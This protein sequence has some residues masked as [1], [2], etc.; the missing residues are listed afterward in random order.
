MGYFTPDFILSGVEGSGF[1]DVPPILL[2]NILTSNKRCVMA[3]P[4]LLR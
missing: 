2:E 3:Y 1:I 4:L